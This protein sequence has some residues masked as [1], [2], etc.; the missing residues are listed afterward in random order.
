MRLLPLATA[1]RPVGGPGVQVWLDRKTSA[2]P[3]RSPST[4]SLALLWNDM[5]D[6]SVPITGK[7]EEAFPVP[8][9]LPGTWL[10]RLIAP[11]PR[12]Y[13]KT[14]SSP[15]VSASPVIMFA[16]AALTNATEDPS[17]EITGDE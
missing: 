2:T 7:A 13:R 12:L 11:P 9:K 4:R 17:N 16:P 8:L 15:F 6:E 1:E 14:S 5:N 3:S 10:T